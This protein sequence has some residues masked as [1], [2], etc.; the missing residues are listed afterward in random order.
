MVCSSCS[1]FCF[2]FNDTATTE[3]YTILFVGSVRCVQETAI[4]SE[5]KGISKTHVIKNK[6][7]FIIQTE[8]INYPAFYNCSKIDHNSIY[9]NDISLI[10]Q[11]YGIEAAR[12]C[13][14][15][16]ISMVFNVYHIS[17]DPRHFSLIADYM[18][19]QGSIRPLNRIGIASAASPFLKMSFETTMQFL[20]NA[21]LYREKED[22]ESL[23]SA[24]VLGRVPKVG[25]GMFDLRHRIK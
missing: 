7:E 22:N 16:E 15:S 12:N 18:T 5:I 4:I 1:V 3:I 21:A 2:F 19:Q 20:T 23:S 14:I 6:Q 17:L 9:S 25:T 8:G 13:L 11:L 24:I 10:L